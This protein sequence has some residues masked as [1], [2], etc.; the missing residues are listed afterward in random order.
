MLHLPDVRSC[1]TARARWLVL[2]WLFVGLLVFTR[3]I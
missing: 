2:T 3:L 1:A